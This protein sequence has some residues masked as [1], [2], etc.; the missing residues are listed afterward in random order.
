MNET[1]SLAGE[2]ADMLLEFNLF[3][4]FSTSDLRSAICVAAAQS[5][6]A[7]NPG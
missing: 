1:S 5:V 2:I 4:D 3:S 6:Q 7:S